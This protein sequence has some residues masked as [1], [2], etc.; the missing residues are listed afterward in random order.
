MHDLLVV[1]I[2][3]DN[4][5]CQLNVILVALQEDLIPAQLFRPL[6]PIP[7]LEEEATK[8]WVTSYQC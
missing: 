2:N 1:G 8:P 3:R 4:I 5:C 7:S 6:A